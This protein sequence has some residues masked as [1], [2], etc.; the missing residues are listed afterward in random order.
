V[1]SGRQLHGQEALTNQFMYYAQSTALSRAVHGVPI[2]VR[3]TVC[4]S[5]CGAR[6]ANPRAPS[7]TT[8]LRGGTRRAQAAREQFLQEKI[9]H[10]A[11]TIAKLINL[12]H[13]HALLVLP[14]CVQQNLRHL[15]RSLKS[16]DRVHLGDKL[17]TTLREAVARIRGHPRPTDQLDAAVISLQIKM[18]GL[19]ILSY[20]TVVPHAYPA[21]SEAADTTLAPIL[22]PGTLPASTQLTTQHQRCQEIFAG[23]REALL[24]SLNPEQAKA[25]VEAPSS[26]GSGSPRYHSSHPSASPTLRLPQRCSCAPSPASGRPTVPTAEKQT[27]SVTHEVCLQRKFRRVARHEGAKHIIGQALAFTPGTRVRLEPLG[28]Q[29][30]RRNDIQVITLLGSQATGLA[31]AEYDLTVVSVSSKDARAT[32]L[33]NQDS[34]RLGCPT[35]T[36]TQL[37][38]TRPATARQAISHSTPSSSPWAA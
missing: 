2:P 13:Q 26:A 11:A 37:L 3:C 22:T 5:P 15:Q 38:T 8:D 4:Q 7:N 36:S 16:D 12:P 17:D 10:E 28:H 35:S 32:Y 23:N 29:T 18:G 33:P 34:D 25:G 31:N 24:G 27:S 30:S 21:A 14:E 19:G 20:K 1:I 6:C 9:N